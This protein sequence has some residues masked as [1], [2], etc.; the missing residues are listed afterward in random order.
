MAAIKPV[1]GA[2]V[3]NGSLAT[4]MVGAYLFNKGSGDFATDVEGSSGNATTVTPPMA[5][6]WSTPSAP[7]LTALDFT[8][9]I[10]DVLDLASIAIANSSVG[11]SI[12]GK[13]IPDLVNNNTIISFSDSA[14]SSYQDSIRINA[15]A[16]FEAWSR[17][18]AVAGQAQG[19]TT[20]VADTPIS[21]GAAFTSLSSRSIY[22]NG[23][24][25]QTETTAVGLVTFDQIYIGALSDSTPSLPFNGEIVYLYI[26][27]RVLS[28]AEFLSVHNDP[29][30][31]MVASGGTGAGSASVGIRR[32]R[33]KSSIHR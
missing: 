19:T 30:Q 2:E 4:G 27:D 33:R 13:I 16:N 8:G 28:D 25:K 20:V 14:E 31:M 5:N 3:L 32:R 22:T 9:S 26:W 6:T 7:D 17:R 29:Y 1:F 23:T 18:I 10:A 11:Y 15:S 24:D 12:A 21:F